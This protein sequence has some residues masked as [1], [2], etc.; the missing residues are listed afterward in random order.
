[1]YLAIYMTT[2]Y[3]L[4]NLVEKGNISR[5][6]MYVNHLLTSCATKN[7]LGI[8]AKVIVDQTIGCCQPQYLKS[9]GGKLVYTYMKVLVYLCVIDLSVVVIKQGHLIVFFYGH[10]QYCSS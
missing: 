5:L 2:L 10:T 1:M 4:T 9:V 7:L 3:K 6:P 8:G